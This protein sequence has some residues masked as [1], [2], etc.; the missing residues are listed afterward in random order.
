LENL[1]EYQRFAKSDHRNVDPNGTTYPGSK[2]IVGGLPSDFVSLLGLVQSGKS[3]AVLDFGRF[4]CVFYCC[5]RFAKE[6]ISFA[7]GGC[8]GAKSE[9]E[10]D[11]VSFIEPIP[12]GPFIF[13]SAIGTYHVALL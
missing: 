8:G 13:V 6:Q 10:K 3:V 2:L 9:D 12:S 7:S 11:E 4:V 5:S 1:S